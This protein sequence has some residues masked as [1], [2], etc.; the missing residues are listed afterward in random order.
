EEV[1]RIFDKIHR[2][3]GWRIGFVYGDLKAKWGWDEEAS[4]AQLARTHTAVQSLQ[5]REREER[6][7]KEERERVVQMG[8]QMGGQMQGGFRPEFAPQ[9]YNAPGGLAGGQG[10]AML[11]PPLPLPP[12]PPP[13]QQQQQQQLPTP[14]PSAA[15]APQKRPPAGIPNPMY[16]KA[17][18]NQPVHP[19]QQY[20]V[21]PNGVAQEG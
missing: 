3:T 7:E 9:Q 1:L 15:A 18:F 5:R 20:Y 17:D 12:P 2:E 11:P 13:P 8:G 10:Q 4:P 21:P 19:Y 16:A 14:T 6:E